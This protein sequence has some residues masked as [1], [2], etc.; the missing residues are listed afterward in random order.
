MSLPLQAEPLPLRTDHGGTIRVGQTRVPLETV[1]HAF[2]EGASA[3]EI[4][5]RY[6]TLELAD[7]YAAITYYLRHRNAVDEYLQGQEVRA[8]EIRQKIETHQPDR[9]GLRER[10]LARRDA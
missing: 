9:Q 3:E 8:K 6:S 5:Y 10:L 1:V 7:I 2:N 4:A